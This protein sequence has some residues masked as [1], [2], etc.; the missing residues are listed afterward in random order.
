MITFLH[1]EKHKSLFFCLEKRW[2]K[3][4]GG[5]GV[6]THWSVVF[7]GGGVADTLCPSPEPHCLLLKGGYHCCKK[8]FNV[9]ICPL[10]YNIV[11]ILTRKLH[12]I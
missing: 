4:G 6:V 10:Q 11:H 7:E 12:M 3:G 1:K 2:F 9:Y 5:G 8:A